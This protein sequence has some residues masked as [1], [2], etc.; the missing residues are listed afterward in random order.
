MQKFTLELLFRIIGIGS[1]SGIF[2]SD[3]TLYLISDNS[4]MLYEY[5]LQDKSLHKN[6]MVAQE[7]YPGPLENLPKK[8]KPDFEALAAKDD[9]LYLFGSGSTAKRNTITRTSL[10][11]REVALTDATDMYLV[12]GDFSGIS[13]EDF[14]IEAAVNDGDTWY[15]FNRGNGPKKQNGIFTLI[16]D[17][18]QLPYQILYNPVTL[19]GIN[20]EAASF[21]DAVKVGNKLYFI[22]A[23]EKTDSTYHDGDVAGSLIGRLD[24]ETMEVEFTQAISS[25]NKFEGI[26]LYKENSTSLEF[27][28]CEDTDTDVMASD[29]YRLSL[30]K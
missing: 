5:R 17:I 13:P 3:G 14:N 25:K 28:L 4:L 10:T 26:T 19:P 7:D 22:A 2:F 21:T 29:I 16:G 6:A 15:L 27:L 24:I 23:A 9:W 1:A 8:D 11:T 20:G 30:E 18:T 12:M